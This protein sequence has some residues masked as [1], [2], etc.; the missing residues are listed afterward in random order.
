MKEYVLLIPFYEVQEQAKLHC[1]EVR[2]AAPSEG[3]WRA[4]EQLRHGVCT[5]L[6]VCMGRAGKAWAV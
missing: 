5:T 3:S 4:G 2:T 6:H 1:R